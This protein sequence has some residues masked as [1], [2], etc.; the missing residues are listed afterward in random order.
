MTKVKFI[1]GI[2][3]R[4]AINEAK[5]RSAQIKLNDSPNFAVLDRGRAK[6]ALLVHQLRLL[7]GY[8][9]D[10]PEYRSALTYAI[11][12]INGYQ[13]TPGTSE[14]ERRVAAELKNYFPVKS[15]LGNIDQAREDLLAL[16]LAGENVSPSEMR[17]ICRDY[18]PDY[19]SNTLVQCQRELE[20]VRMASKHISKSGHHMM[21]EFANA[22]APESTVTAKRVDHVN[23][24]SVLADITKLGRE[25]MRTW[26]RTS[27][28]E[29]HV[30]QQ[31]MPLHPEEAIQELRD[32][33]GRGDSISA[34]PLAVAIIGAVTSALTAAA[35]LV[36]ALR[37]DAARLQSAAQG[38]SLD[39]F[40]PQYSDFPQMGPGTPA[41]N[42]GGPGSGLLSENSNLLP[43][44]LGAGGLLLLTSG[45]NN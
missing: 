40:G 14:V 43:I 21:Y 7:S 9:S 18:Y 22:N 19:T 5:D 26:V 29:G 38:F 45:K 30:K 3:R 2:P 27:V 24:V 23:A 25:N 44:L 11:D 20:I 35:G 1:Q 42:G 32:S 10:R 15:K 31:I 36:S 17:A 13:R 28:M 6:G 39:T 12:Y 41:G 4:T 33:A 8:Y 34:V 16:I 37:G